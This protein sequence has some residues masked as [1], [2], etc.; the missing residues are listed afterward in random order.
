[1]MKPTHRILT[2]SSR[3]AP[4]RSP[5]IQSGQSDGAEPQQLPADLEHQDGQHPLGVAQPQQGEHRHGHE[6]REDGPPLGSHGSWETSCGPFGDR[7]PDHP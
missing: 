2:V 4:L 7:Q 1:M 3:V 5:S 6:Q